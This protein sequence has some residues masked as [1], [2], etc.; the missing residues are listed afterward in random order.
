MYVYAFSRGRQAGRQALPPPLLRC[1]FSLM[2]S[3]D[4]V[5]RINMWNVALAPVMDD[6]GGVVWCG[7]VHVEG[8]VW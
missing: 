4:G 1:S 8:E 7:V 2:H 6:G 3:L 5:E